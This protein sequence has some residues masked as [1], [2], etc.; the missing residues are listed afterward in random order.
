MNAERLDHE[1]TLRGITKSEMCKLLGISRSALYR[2]RKGVSQ[3]TQ[4][5]MQ[6]IIA[7]LNL[8]NSTAIEIFFSHLVS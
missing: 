3:F 4:R 6:K 2:K 5:E 7:C 1:M 8:E